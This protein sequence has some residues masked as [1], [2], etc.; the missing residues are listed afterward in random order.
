MPI[1][2]CARLARPYF[3]LATDTESGPEPTLGGRI[4]FCNGTGCLSCLQLLDQNEM[5]R[6]SMN[7]EHKAARDRTYGIPMDALD[8]TGPAVVS[9]NGAVACSHRVH[10]IRDRHHDPGL[11]LELDGEKRLI[12]KSVDAARPN[13]VYCSEL[14]GNGLDDAI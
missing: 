11:G 6:D 13:C 4:A 7:P 8:Q 1:E 9:V 12:R 2:I 5:A 14:W 3:D 10:G